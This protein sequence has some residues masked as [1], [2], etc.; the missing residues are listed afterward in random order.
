MLRDGKPIV[1]SRPPIEGRSARHLARRLGQNVRRDGRWAKPR[2]SAS[3]ARGGIAALART[4][5]TLL[6]PSYR[7]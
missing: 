1:S 3:I 2:A 4:L 6:T 5:K 7:P